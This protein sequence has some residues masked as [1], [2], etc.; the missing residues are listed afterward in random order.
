MALFHPI[1]RRAL[2]QRHGHDL[3]PS[4]IR[5]PANLPAALSQTGSTLEASTTKP[6]AT[7][8]SPSART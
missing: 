7:W 3:D 2:A 5:D 8:Q 1:G 6:T 4:D